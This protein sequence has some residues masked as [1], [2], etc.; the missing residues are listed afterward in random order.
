MVY[1]LFQR[2]LV[3]LDGS[4]H[5]FKALEEAAQ[6]AKL[7]SGEITLVHVYS[8]PPINTASVVPSNVA[9]W[10]NF[11]G[12]GSSHAGRGGQKDWKQNFGRW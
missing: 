6:L 4:E 3:P 9:I 5:S 8:M 7:F 1:K 10:A 11:N 2:I 12:R